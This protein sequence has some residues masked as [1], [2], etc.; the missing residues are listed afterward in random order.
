[1]RRLTLI[2]SDLYLPEEAGRGAGARGARAAASRLAAA[3]CG[4]RSASA[5]GARGSRQSSG[6]A[7]SAASPVAQSAR[8]APR[9]RRH[10]VNAGSRRPCI[11]KRGSITC[12]CSIA[13][14]CARCGR[15]GELAAR[16]SRAFRPDIALHDAGERGFL[17]S[18]LARAAACDRRS[19]A[20]ARRRHR[21]GVAAGRGRRVAPARGGNRDVAARRRAQCGARARPEPR[22]S[23]LW[24][25]GGGTTPA[26]GAPP[27]RRPLRLSTAATLLA[28]LARADRRRRAPS[29]RP[30]SMSMRDGSSGWSN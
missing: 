28:A 19:G 30:F 9:Y 16:S 22:V 29:P 15:A 18:G 10:R 17:L 25:W 21:P 12:G 8:T 4:R 11:S 13:V 2:L 24:L 1:M 23:A 14:C 27:R 26:R 7:H 20:P 3:I 6:V 5:T